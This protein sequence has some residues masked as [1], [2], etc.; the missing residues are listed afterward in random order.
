M[1]QLLVILCILL[2]TNAVGQTNKNDTVTF[3][4]IKY[5]VP[6]GCKSE[7]LPSVQ[8]DGWKMT[9]I[10]LTPEML[11]TFPDQLVNKI[12]GQ[13]KK[14]KKEAIDCYLLFNPAKGY[15][16]S[17]KTDNGT[18]VYQLIV[19]GVANEQPVIVQLSLNK[20]PESNEDIP[21]FARQMIRLTK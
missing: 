11:Q 6:A 5:P 18:S 1:K 17:F 20:E 3:C 9:W 8:C 10:Y 21:E 19:Y 7:P 12:A 4:Y 15:L 2:A 16:L 14:F 13:F